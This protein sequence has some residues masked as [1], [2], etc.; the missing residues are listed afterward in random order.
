[1]APPKKSGDL[2]AEQLLALNIRLMQ[3]LYEAGVV[4]IRLERA[5][6]ANQ[7]PD[8]RSLPLL[9]TPADLRKN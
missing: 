6:D 3:S 7:W 5:L 4:R 8:F 2:T 9:P 1:M